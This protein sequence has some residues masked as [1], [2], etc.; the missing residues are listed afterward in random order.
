MD[1]IKWTLP[2]R[3]EIDNKEMLKTIK[4]LHDEDGAT[5]NKPL[6][7]LNSICTFDIETTTIE[8]PVRP[9]AFMYLWQFC[10]DN[11]EVYMGRT[12]KEFRA[13][14]SQ[15]KRDLRLSPARR[16]V[17]YVHN[18]SYE[19]QFIHDFLEVYEVFEMGPHKILSFMAEGIEFRCS[20]LLTNMSLAKLCANT[21]TCKHNKLSGAEFN[22]NIKRTP[23]TVLRDYE[24]EYAYND[25]KGLAE[26]IEYRLQDET[27]VTIPK[28]STGYV[29][30]EMR[31]NMKKD[32]YN[33]DTFEDSKLDPFLYQL[34]RRAFRGGDTH[35]NPAHTGH[36][37]T[38]PV[39]VKDIK[40][41]YPAALT[42]NTYPLGKFS[43]VE[44]DEYM[45][46][47]AENNKTY[48]S[49][50]IVIYEGIEY[51]APDNMPYL[52]AYKCNEL[53]N[54]IYDN[55]RVRYAD[56]LM[57]VL[58]DID[59]QITESSYKYK[60]RI[61]TRVFRSWRGKLSK[62]FR[63]T[64][65]EFFRIKTQ[66]DGIP[67]RKYEYN[68]A[69]NKLNSTYGL[70]VMRLD[71][72]KSEWTEGEIV[73]T[74]ETLED[75]LDK[76][77]KSRNN[78]LPYQWGVWCTAWARLR[79]RVALQMVGADAVYCDTD[80]VFYIGDH[81][82][83]FEDLNIKLREAAIKNGAYC[84]DSK[85]NVLYMGIYEQDKCFSGG[86]YKTLGSKKYIGRLEDGK[87]YCTIAGVSKDRG[88]AFFDKEGFDA[89][90]DGTTITDSGHLVAY[91]N[92]SA[93]HVINYDGCDILTA[94]NVALVNQDYTL[95]MDDDYL[96]LIEMQKQGIQPIF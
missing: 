71:R 39:N 23:K 28:T 32:K 47:F 3:F 13:F 34:C 87:M 29:R 77:Y 66:L 94:S 53:V 56:Y 89:F 19:W 17:V 69:K 7:Y 38:E 18:L 21:P 65:M 88:A 61:I 62:E 79:L 67:E 63:E 96:R 42:E 64:V 25:V 12:F 40:S 91:Y 95:G 73:Q 10:F 27:L 2:D 9:Y 54:C 80:S 16:L 84:E 20:Y 51:I 45:A 6:Y 75:I 93:K 24:L 33:R 43:E 1:D 50:I 5:Y 35:S 59:F 41:S 55:G 26:C 74:S 58:T 11:K 92:D 37:I 4:T 49:L 14:I 46:N 72:P 86:G 68:K 70:C 60:N 90:E 36:T 83:E 8:D 81:E 22:Y 44:P 57:T 85:G 30:R 82:K 78:F 31:Q 52:P 76:Y 15:L 48:C